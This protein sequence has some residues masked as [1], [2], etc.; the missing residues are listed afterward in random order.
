[1]PTFLT[2]TKRILS[3]YAQRFRD[4]SAFVGVYQS[5]ETPVAEKPLKAVLSCY[6]QQHALVRNALPGKLIM[7]SP[8]WDARKRC[9]TGVNIASVRAGIG[10]IART[11]VDII[12]PQDSRGTGKVGLFWKRQRGDAVA[13]GLR[14]VDGVGDATYA[15]AYHASTRSFYRAAREAVDALSATGLK[16]QLWANLEA[17][18]PG[19]GIPCGNFTT[20]Q[21][22]TKERLDRQIM[23]AGVYP[24]KLIS[25][26]WD[27]Y[28]TC[29]AGHPETLADAIAVDHGRP[30]LARA[31]RY[32]DRLVVLGYHLVEARLEVSDGSRPLLLAGDGNVLEALPLGP[33]CRYPEGVMQVAGPWPEG[34]G[35]AY[36][37]VRVRTPK[38][39]SQS[40]ALGE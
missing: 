5:L 3:D 38:G 22:T 1:M 39:W 26:M 34:A 29:R 27:S 36:T 14:C 2:F 7:V 37:R 24:E 13:A 25:Y 35:S 31:R 18:A 19:K 10:H 12:A 4:S 23:M 8:Y 33:V 15:E 11:D 20:S 28:Y 9:P 16:V 21:R 32:G 40:L 17:F 30:I 6:R